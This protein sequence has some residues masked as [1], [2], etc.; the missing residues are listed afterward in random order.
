M[1]E[2]LKLSKSIKNQRIYG[3]LKWEVDFYKVTKKVL[4]FNYYR[5]LT[6]LLWYKISDLVYDISTENIEL[7]KYK[8][9]ERG[10]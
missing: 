2:L 8:E 6:S 10:E 7:I 4:T 9:S 5:T 3:C 1:L